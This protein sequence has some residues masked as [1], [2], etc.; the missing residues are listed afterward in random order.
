MCLHLCKQYHSLMKCLSCL[1]SSL[2]L[3]ILVVM[4]TPLLAQQR[5]FCDLYGAVMIEKNLSQAQYKVY[6][7]KSEAFADLPVFQT[8]NGLFADRSGLWYMTASRAQAKFTIA[9]VAEKS[10]ADF[11]IFYIDN[12]SF[13]GCR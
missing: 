8:A 2:V 6:I 12:E 1:F 7:E 9:I 10:M 3:T 4:A 5:D 11:S 13:A